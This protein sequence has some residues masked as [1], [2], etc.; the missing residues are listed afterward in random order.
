M[1]G[2]ALALVSGVVGAGGAILSAVVANRAGERQRREER[3][4]QDKQRVEDACVDFVRTLDSYIAALSMMPFAKRAPGRLDRLA[5]RFFGDFLSFGALLL[6]RLLFGYRWERLLDDVIA[7]SARL[8]V[9]A[10][11]GIRTV[12]DEVHALLTSGPDLTKEEG[13]RQWRELR[14]ALT[15]TL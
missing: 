13:A 5:E 4:H 6:Q 3:H 8:R 2:E 12:M 14:D 15:A 1:E 7:S 11:K 10:P 9:V